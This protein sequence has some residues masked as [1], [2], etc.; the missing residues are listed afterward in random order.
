MIWLLRVVYSIFEIQFFD[1]SGRVGQDELN[2]VSQF[3]IGGLK[4]ELWCLEVKNE[5]SLENLLFCH[6]TLTN[7]RF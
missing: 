6:V 2:T 4:H 1:D 3:E 5:T 7:Q